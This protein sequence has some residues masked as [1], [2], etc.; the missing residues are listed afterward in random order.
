M[1]SARTS[2]ASCFGTGCPPEC[3][4]PGLPSL[5]VVPCGHVFCQPC[6]TKR[7]SLGLT[8]RAMVPAHCCGVEFPTE[9]VKDALGALDFTTYARYLAER[10]WQQTSLRSDAEYAK[11]VQLLGGMQCPHCGIGVTR[12]SG[13]EHMK[14]SHC[15]TAFNYTG[16]SG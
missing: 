13:C 16:C 7:C 11:T 14:C 15:G 6:I 12:I 8:D 9:Y 10:Q 2:C 1:S 3:P 5:R 4:A